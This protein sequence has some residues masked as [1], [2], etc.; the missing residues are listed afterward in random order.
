MCDISYNGDNIQVRGFAGAPSAPRTTKRGL[1]VY[2]NGRFIRDR[3]IDHAV[4]EAYHGR[5]IKGTFPVAVLFVTVPPTMVDV[6]VHPTKSAVR[7]AAP[8]QVHDGVVTAITSAL[9][10]LDRP[11]VIKKSILSP[12]KGSIEPHPSYSRDA[13]L[14]DHRVRRTVE[15]GA[16]RACLE[17]QTNRGRR[18]STKAS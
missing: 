18:F 1:Y 6:N 16:D 8:K 13:M 2:V 14:F 9:K 7:F 5:L 3:V 17:H 10:S 12:L 15:K 11:G 4:L